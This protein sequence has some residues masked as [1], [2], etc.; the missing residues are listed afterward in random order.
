MPY[1]GAGVAASAVGMDKA[2]FHVVAT[3][4]GIP[5]VETLIVSHSEWQDDPSGVRDRVAGAVGYPAFAKPARL[6]SSYGISPVPD[7]DALTPALQL[8]FAHDEGHQMIGA[9]AIAN[10]CPGWEMYVTMFVESLAR[11]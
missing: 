11:T 1:V 8:A 2:L 10:R 9:W 3:A 6:G 4:A 5:R 7:E